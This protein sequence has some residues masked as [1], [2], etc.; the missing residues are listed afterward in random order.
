[1]IRTIRNAALILA[2]SL[3]VLAPV[4]S[5]DPSAS[6]S[7][8]VGVTLRIPPRVSVDR[9]EAGSLWARQENATAAMLQVVDATGEKLDRC[10]TTI[11]RQISSSQNYLLVTPV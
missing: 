3:P 1:M 5:A 2:M 4:A 11:A 8:S 9:D 6:A 7:G 10:G